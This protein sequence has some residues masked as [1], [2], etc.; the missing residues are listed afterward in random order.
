VKVVLSWLREFCPTELSAE[1]LADV[2]SVKGVHVEGIIRPW[3]GLS[4]VVVARVLEVRDHPNSDKLCLARV[5]DGSGEREVVVGVRNMRAGDMVPLAPPGARVPVLD[6]AL[7]ARS[8]RGVESSGMLCSPRELAISGEHLGILIL[9]GDAPVGADVKA[10]L[11]LD[12]AVLDIEIEPNRPDLMSV[13]GVARE[14]AAATGVPLSR[15]DPSV[16]ESDRDAKESATVEVLDLARCPLYV[17][18]VISGVAVGPSPLRV[19]ARLSAS[20]MRP[21]SNVVDATNY[22]MLETGQPLHAFD[23]AS[24]SGRGIVV[25]RAVEGEPLRTLD[26]VERILSAQDLVIADLQ[27]AMAIAGIMGSA[28]AEVGPGTTEVLLESAYFEPKGVLRTSRRL[29]L[30]TEASMRFGRGADPEGPSPGAALAARL[31]TEW[32]GGA[33][34]RGEVRAGDVPDRRWV[35][36]RPSRAGALIGYPV[37]ADDAEDALGRSG[38]VTRRRAEDS[39]EVEV[40]GY[41]VDLEREVDLIEEIVRVQGYDRLPSTLPAIR[42]VG[43]VTQTYALHRRA[44]AALVRAGMREALSLSFASD[45]DLELIGHGPGVRLANPV[46][47]DEPYLRTSLLPSLLRAA[48]RNAAHGARGLALFE[49]GHV[50][51]PGEPVREREMAAAVVS[52]E[53]GPGYP[54]EA[55]S[56]DFFDAKGA[57]ESFLEAMAVSGWDLAE[58]SGE[59]A[60]HPTRSASVLVEGEP[61][62]VLGELHPRLAE[63]LD[64]PAGSAAFELDLTALSPHVGR[65]MEFK[66]VPRFPPARRDLAFMV[67]ASVPVGILRDGIL[68]AANGLADRVVLFDVFSGASLPAGKKSV[69]FSVEFRSPDRT[70]TDEEVGRAVESVAERL[71]KDAGAELRTS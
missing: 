38:L 54:A 67:D 69:A 53:A 61:V 25:R 2:L 44:T 43:G 18:R 14:V 51:S 41:R 42:Q 22:A 39:V 12:D 21:L 30:A 23:L 16:P 5:A 26:E 32:S 55:R 65:P 59:P 6:E 47:G 8:I 63:R 9:P 36:V 10:F 15:P 13:F 45:A 7:T 28:A 24:L 35:A 68:R 64:L 37:G 66:D 31:M 33:V 17:A 1:E 40:P 71:R 52:G 70:L 57:L 27:V 46:S 60:F 56:F 49:V 58:I 20:G 29:A 11:G 50:F 48:S 3:E 4:G 62:G 34:L 19:Q